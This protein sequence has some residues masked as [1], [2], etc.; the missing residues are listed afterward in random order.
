M[1]LFCVFE[2][3]HWY[4][5][6]PEYFDENGVPSIPSRCLWRLFAFL[7]HL[8]M[9][10]HVSP[11]WSKKLQ[12]VVEHSWHV[13]MHEKMLDADKLFR[14]LERFWFV[15]VYWQYWAT[16]NRMHLRLRL[17]IT[18]LCAINPPVFKWLTSS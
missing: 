5:F 13:H 1:L 16:F 17:P 8:S 15:C 4:V 18:N 11:N 9:P 2:S 12:K 6:P 10:R 14:S 3:L 7:S